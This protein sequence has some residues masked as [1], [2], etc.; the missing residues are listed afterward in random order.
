M[1][2]KKG[3]IEVLTTAQFTE[4]NAAVNREIR[5][6]WSPCPTQKQGTEEA[7]DNTD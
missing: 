4:S 7:L 1:E 5:S 6:E 2:K 3:E